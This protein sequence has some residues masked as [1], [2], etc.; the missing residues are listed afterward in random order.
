MS[1]GTLRWS[2]YTKRFLPL[3]DWYAEKA[4]H[5][6]PV[7]RSDLPCPMIISDGIE[8]KSMLDG[9]T[10]TSKRAYH[11]SLRKGGCEVVY[12]EDLQKYSAPTYDEKAH[13]NEIAS[14]VKTAIEQIEGRL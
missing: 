11:D 9:Q 3:N 8:M 13:T 1:R 6:I 2:T 14:D 4:A 5:S 12:G 10:Y 7:A